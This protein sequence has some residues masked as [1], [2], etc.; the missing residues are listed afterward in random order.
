[1]VAASLPQDS[2]T[3]PLATF[4]TC[5]LPSCNSSSTGLHTV[6]SAVYHGPLPLREEAQSLRLTPG[7]SPLCAAGK[8]V[9]FMVGQKEASFTSCV[10]NA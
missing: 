7:L 6:P 5:F 9:F 2:L 10:F 4:S 8:Q 1:M 3:E